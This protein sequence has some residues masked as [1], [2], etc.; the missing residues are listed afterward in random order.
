MWSQVTDWQSLEQFTNPVEPCDS[1]KRPIRM[2]LPRRPTP[3]PSQV[4][5]LFAAVLLVTLAGC[6]GSGGADVGLSAAEDAAGGS[7]GDSRSAPAAQESSDSQRAG[8]NRTT[9]QTRAVIQTGVISLTNPDLD[10]ARQEATL[11]L[12]RFGGFVAEEQT[13]HDKRG[14]VASSRLVVRVPSSGF[15]AAMEAFSG[16]GKVEVAEQT[17]EDVTT[18]VIDV[19]ARVRAQELSLREL[20]G[21]LQRSAAL[22]D[23]IRLESEIAKRQQE[24]DS[25][26]ARQTY[27][28]DQTTMST[29]TVHMS[30]PPPVVKPPEALDDAGFLAG[31][32]GGWNALKIFFVAVSTMLGAALPFIV[33]LAVAGVPLWLLARALT[34]R[35]LGLL[36]PTPAG[37]ETP[38]D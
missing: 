1:G 2:N 8:A 10:R 17:S 32:K 13:S 21:F 29:I 9:I 27:L 5:A 38:T 33:V 20:E 22:E 34:R 14:K 37:P 4:A 24:L 36:E 28:E 7:S 25:L 31:L 6:T 15:T 11:L 35:R 18:E 12:D 19:E 26:K 3:R 16:L 30:T 23:I